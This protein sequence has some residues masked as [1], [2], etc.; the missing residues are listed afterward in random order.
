MDPK[1]VLVFEPSVDGHHVG[2]LR[3]ITEDLLGAGF[4]LT[5]A[6]DTRAEAMER[7][8][9]QMADLLPRVQVRSAFP[10]AGDRTKATSGAR[11][12]ACLRESGVAIA[13][14]ANFNDLAS[15]LLRRAALGLLPDESLR[16]RLGGIYFRPLFL[17]AGALSLNQ[18]LK[19]IGF[20][21]LVQDSWL[22]PLLMIDPRLCG[23]AQKKYPGA[24]IHLLA[25][26]YPDHF[27]ADRAA[28]RRQFN[29][30]D[31]KFVFLFYGGGYKRKGLHLVVEAMRHMA[32]PGRAFLLCAGLQPQDEQLARGLE[33]LRSQ[34]RAE[35]VNRYISAQEEKQVFA[36]CDMVLLPYL[37]HLDGSGVLSRAA[38]AGKPALAS[39]EYLIG[40]V[41]RH[42]GMGLLF[43]SGNVPELRHAMLRAA[44]ASGAE[45]ARWQAGAQ[46]YAAK[47]SRDA[48]RSV[49][50]AAVRS[51]LAAQ[52]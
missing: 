32:A 24:P 39:D 18:T 34:G 40:H 7:I 12:A 51:A 29:L 46:T 45:I 6:L 10:A 15:S 2:W 47:C 11:V 52:K 5:L 23:I 27:T 30:P 8:A 49:L 21:R 17:S 41:V 9:G 20:R 26:P 36:A 48:F 37:G 38:G 33:T 14:L 25:D 16:S 22:N 13:F 28:S 19:K 35:I 43:Q 44:T 4:S 50:I 3:F 1:S 42:H 31:D